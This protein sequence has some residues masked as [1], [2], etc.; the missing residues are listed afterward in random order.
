MSRDHLPTE[1][2]NAGSADLDLLTVSQA[3]DVMNAEDAGVAASVARAKADIV[4]AVELVADRLARGGRLFH[5]GAG[6]SGRLGVLDAAEC[7]PTFRTDPA[8]VQGVIAGG[9]K[10]LVSAVEGA[11]DDRAAGA[12]DL[13]ERGVGA[14]DV[15]LGIAAGG[16]TPYVHGALAHARAAGAATIFLACVPKELVGDEADVSI[17]VVTGPELIAGSTRLKAGTATKMVLNAV[18][19]L[20][21]TRLGKVHGNLMVDV[22]TLGN[23]KLRERGIGLVA[24]LVPCDRKEAEGLLDRAGGSVKLAVVMART[25][26]SQPEARARLQGADGVLRRALE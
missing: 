10:A 7:P 18:T 13:A 4:R 14:S 20:A 16:T 6:T 22:A 15:V 11:E 26:S 1:Q 3:F 2:V 24:Q 5:V 23:A 9:S 25:G 17:R 21:M 12:R 19:T 8:Q